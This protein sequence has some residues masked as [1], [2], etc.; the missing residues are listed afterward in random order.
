MKKLIITDNEYIY[1]K[2]KQILKEKKLTNIFDFKY[3]YNNMSFNHKYSLDEIKPINIKKE[4]EK[5]IK[6]Y[7]LIIY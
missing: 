2:T 7:D 4:K 1:E 3:S 6:E 5:L